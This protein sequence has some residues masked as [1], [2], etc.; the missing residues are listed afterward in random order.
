[1]EREPGFDLRMA[2]TILLGLFFNLYLFPQDSLLLALPAIL[3]YNYLRRRELPY[4]AYAAFALCCPAVFLIAEFTIGSKL[5][6][7]IPVWAIMILLVWMAF[8]LW[9]ESKHGSRAIQPGSPL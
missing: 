8:T 9:K 2:F 4:R 5:G 6:L 3:F 1:M 7:R